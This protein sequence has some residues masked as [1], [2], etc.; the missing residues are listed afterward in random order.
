VSSAAASREGHASAQAP[1]RL[2]R[3][4][5]RPALAAVFVLL[6]A[7]YWLTVYPHVS[8]HLRRARARA[9]SIPYPTLRELVLASLDKRSN[10]EGA[11]A[12]AVLAP[13]ATRRSALRALLAFQTIYN[14]ADVLAEQPDEQSRA[15]ARRAHLPLAYALGAGP[16]IAS[17]YAGGPWMRDTGYLAEQITRCRQAIAE[18]PSGETVR[19]SALRSAADIAEF[20]AH[21]R[22]AATPAE[23]EHWA[24]SHPPRAPSMSWWETSAACGSSLAVH[25]LIAAAASPGLQQPDVQRLVEVYGGPVGALHSMLDSLIDQDEDA[26]LGQPSLIGLYPSALAATRAMG[27]M[28]NTARCAARA[29]PQG[30]RHA[31]LLGAMAALYLSDPQARSARAAPLAA[32]VRAGIGR[33]ATPAMVVFAVRRLAARRTRPTGIPRAV[34]QSAGA[35]RERA[36]GACPRAG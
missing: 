34:Q 33:L 21:S 22:P 35:E 9:R 1:P 12:F 2:G 3:V 18:L 4:R 7:R 5:E 20:Q 36:P 19:E 31:V 23:L 6:A 8:A 32:A 25:A 28:A 29:L 15:D 11:A 17:L 24:R 16:P 27:A 30:C 13:R 10:I 14:Y 26:I